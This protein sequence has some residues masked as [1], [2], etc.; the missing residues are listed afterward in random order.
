MPGPVCTVC[1]HA[2]RKEIDLLLLSPA[3]P[4]LAEIAAA[5]SLSTKALSRH[6]IK[7]IPAALARAV[8][9]TNLR[10]PI[11]TVLDQIKTIAGRFEATWDTVEKIMATAAEEK[12]PELALKAVGKAVAVGRELRN[13]LELI[14]KSTGELKSSEGISGGGII[15]LP[16]MVPVGTIA[17]LGAEIPKSEIQRALSE[18]GAIDATFETSQPES[19]LTGAP[20]L[21]LGAPPQRDPEHDP[22]HDHE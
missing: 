8:E 3:C 7:H 2:Q 12:H 6:Q 22:E 10:G 14:G 5:Y 9:V 11:R 18:R 16:V 17:D 20:P 21:A 4:T 19:A 15:I 1:R 13:T